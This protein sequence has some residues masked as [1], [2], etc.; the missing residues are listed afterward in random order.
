MGLAIFLREYFRWHYGKALR[1][2][3]TLGKNFLWFFWHF[4]SVPL[5]SRTLFSPFRRLSEQYK[6]GFD[7]GAILESFIVNSISRVT[8]FF[9]RSVVILMGLAAESV[10]TLALAPVFLLWVLLPFGIVI[11]F[12]SGVGLIFF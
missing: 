12:A 3:L 8:G 9:L 10:I 11:L 4:F 5:L 7:P 2:I 6:K 1:D